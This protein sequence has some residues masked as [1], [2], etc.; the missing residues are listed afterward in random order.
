MET[1]EYSHPTVFD[2]QYGSR[3]VLDVLAEKWT[4]LVL[5]ALAFGVKRHGELKREIKGISQKMLTLTLRNLEC[6]GLVKRTVYHVVPPRVEYA[7]TPLGQTFSEL[8]MAIC[9]WAET[10]FAAIEGARVDY[11]HKAKAVGS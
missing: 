11:D 2:W 8:L 9:T 1:K 10:H 6:D 4:A 5:C 3:Q 7:L